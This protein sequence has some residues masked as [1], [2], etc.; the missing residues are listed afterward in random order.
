MNKEELKKSVEELVEQLSKLEQ[1]SS[2]AQAEEQVLE[3]AATSESSE[4]VEKSM[5]AQP[6][7]GQEPPHLANLDANGGDDKYKTGSPGMEEQKDPSA[8]AKEAKKSEDE[9]EE[10]ESLEPKA[11]K[12]EKSEEL[13]LDDEEVELVK[14]WRAQKQE[15]SIEKAVPAQADSDVL[16]KAFQKENDD[17]KKALTEQSDL[18]KSLSEKV[19][20]MASA[21]AYDKRAISGLEPI[22]KS[23]DQESELNKSQVLDKMLQLQQDEKS[24]VHARHIAEFEATGNLSNPQIKQLVINSFNKQ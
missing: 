1:E 18:I 10:E 14:A 5:P 2:E 7:L 17:L 19:E 11:E 22:E 8:K 24:G 15:E 13:S 23:G 9:E 4:E 21:P 12:V 3:G 16:V 20:K 6:E